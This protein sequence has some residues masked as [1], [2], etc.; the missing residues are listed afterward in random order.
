MWI[1]HSYLGTRRGSTRCLFFLLFEDYI[2]AQRGLDG[3]VKRELERFARNL[4]DSGAVVLPFP[5]DAPTTTASVLDKPWSEPEREEL[6]QTPAMLMIGTDFDDFD[7]RSH[8]W[9]LFHFD[10][11]AGDDG[12]QAA[13]LRSLFQKFVAA[14]ADPDSDP[15]DAVRA[16]LRNDTLAQSSKIFSLEPGLFG[17]SVDLRTG[18]SAL[19]DYL[20]LRANQSKD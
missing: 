2:D 7:P 13:K 20:R 10:R 19:K 12:S 4:G 11:S 15:F 9:V 6:R 3:K 18:W 8:S 1:T 14:T 16:A 17:V 5:G